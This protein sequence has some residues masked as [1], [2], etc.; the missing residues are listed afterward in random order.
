MKLNHDEFTDCPVLPVS[1]LQHPVTPEPDA[2]P[3]PEETGRARFMLVAE[4]AF[5]LSLSVDAYRRLLSMALDHPAVFGMLL[6][7]T[8]ETALF[9]FHRR[10]KWTTKPHAVSVAFVG[11]GGSLLFMDS[12]TSIAP[13]MLTAVMIA[14]G[15]AISLGAKWSLGRSF[16]L[17]PA[18]RG[19]RTSGIYNLVRHPI[20]A[21]YLWS[22]L[23]FVLLRPSAW[24]I[25]LFAVIWTAQWLRMNEEEALLEQDE[26]YRAYKARVRYRLI[27]GVL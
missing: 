1:S 23:G 9:V 5:F 6:C 12:G 21:G 2:D 19:L 7:L 17:I 10:G 24:N 15:S 4:W 27:P 3:A 8:V 26:R 18:N 11:T 13:E 14:V 16:G 25:A 20:Y 22:N